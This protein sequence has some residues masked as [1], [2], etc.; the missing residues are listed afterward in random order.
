MMEEPARTRGA[1]DVAWALRSASLCPVGGRANADIFGDTIV[2]LHADEHR[3]RRRIE[4]RLFRADALRYYE[5]EVLL[6]AIDECLAE[7]AAQRDVDGFVR[8]NLKRL[9]TEIILRVSMAIIGIDDRRPQTV[10]R[11]YCFLEPLTRAHEIEYTTE[12]HDEVLRAAAETKA[13]LRDEFVTP[14]LQRR[15]ALIAAGEEL[16]PDLIATLAAD[17]EIDDDLIVRE[18][19]LY[20]IASVFTTTTTI[21]NTVA[22]LL[23]WFEEHP[24]DR[25]L[26]L[27]PADEFLRRAIDESLRRDP[28]ITPVLMRKAAESVRLPSGLS[29]DRGEPLACDIIGAH[30][31]ARLFGADPQ[32]FDPY[33]EPRGRARP[34]YWAFG[35][36]PHVC[37]GLPLV[38]GSRTAGT[39]GDTVVLVR[40]LLR[41][42]VEVDDRPPELAPSRHKRYESF[43]VV[44]RAL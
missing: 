30:Q 27:E 7:V 32:A 17:A 16:P 25:E 39:E 19:A 36:G 24:D 14:S 18:A 21:I 1:R 44:L 28:P 5:H 22:A 8:T 43:P 29:V 33:R 40:A 11:L 34:H 10:A 15:R 38:M 26:A 37:I 6:P 4:G 23:G 31:D 42:G 9:V 12:R 41:A 13:Q 35:D 2:T 20:L 3:V